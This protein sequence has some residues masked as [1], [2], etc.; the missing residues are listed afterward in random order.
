MNSSIL[1]SLS[2]TSPMGFDPLANMLN[3]MGG[4]KNP[5]CNRLS[6]AGSN[7]VSQFIA[8]QT[9]TIAEKGYSTILVLVLFFTMVAFSIIGV[10]SAI[11]W[12]AY[13][14][15]LDSSDAGSGSN[16]DE[17]AGRYTSGVLA[18]V[19]GT[20]TVVT[21]FVLIFYLYFKAGSCKSV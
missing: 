13:Q 3:H 15:D 19:F 14:A 21:A 20:L 5:N 7:A 12:G 1:S 16:E 11:S 2:P 17:L 6:G 18:M 10:V 4:A 9:T 8:K